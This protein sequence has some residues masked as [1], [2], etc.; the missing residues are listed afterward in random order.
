MA[1]PFLRRAPLVLIAALGPLIAARTATAQPAPPSASNDPA[2]QPAPIASPAPAPT[3]PPIAAPEPPPSSISAP[4]P[5]PSPTAAPPS[6][7]AFD[8]NLGLSRAAAPYFPVSFALLHPISTNMTQSELH[9]NLG[10]A[11]IFGR[12]G[13]LE[14]LQL[15]LINS[16]LHDMTGVQLGVASVNEGSTNGLQ[17]GGVFSYADGPLRGLQLSGVFGWATAPIVGAQIAGVANQTKAGVRG[18]QLSGAFN[19]VRGEQRVDGVQ[20]GGV[21]LGRVNG[22]QLGGLNVS[23]EVRGLQIGLINVARKIDGLQIGLINITDNL[24]GESFG[25]A[26]VPRRGGVHLMVWGS[27]SLSGNLGVKFASRYTYS[28]LSSAVHRDGKDTVIAAGLTFG[29]HFPFLIPALSW[30]GDLGGYRLFRIDVPKTTHDEMVKTRLLVSY[31]IAR[32]FSIFAGGGAYVSV[33]GDSTLTSKFG[34][35]L[36]AGLDL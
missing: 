22:L 19:I 25:V 21:N 10:V 27:N 5:T 1:L 28:V 7:S 30:S 6:P 23:E 11:L 35:E 4:P 33:R 20:I 8:D 3:P 26:S 16:T 9:T 24:E 18:L 14:G 32:H 29:V 15:G 13:Y 31:E 12:V 2:P 36:C 17:L 34:P